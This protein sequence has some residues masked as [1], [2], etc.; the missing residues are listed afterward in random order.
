MPGPSAPRV[1]SG[2]DASAASKGPDERTAEELVVLQA[3][4][5]FYHFNLLA[6]P[7]ALDYLAQRGISLATARECRLGYAAGN[8]LLAFLVRRGGAD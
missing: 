5:N 3:A 4:T 1:T 8:Q 7:R 2:A 6:E